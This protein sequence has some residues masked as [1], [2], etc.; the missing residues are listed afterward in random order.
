[1][2]KK[3]KDLG[4]YR[5]FLDDALENYGEDEYSSERFCYLLTLPI[6]C[7]VGMYRYIKNEGV[8][9][10]FC[11]YILNDLRTIMANEFDRTF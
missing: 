7:I 10:K 11:V 3:E 8:D 9:T 5:K 4:L 1:M 6:S 2:C